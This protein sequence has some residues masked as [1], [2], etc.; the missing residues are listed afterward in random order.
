MPEDTQFIHLSGDVN[1]L[2]SSVG[3]CLG[4]SPLSSALGFWKQIRDGK[5][6]AGKRMGLVELPWRPEQGG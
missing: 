2:V 6:E 5:E 4:V 3:Q 1:S